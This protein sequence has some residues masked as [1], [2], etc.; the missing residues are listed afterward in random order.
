MTNKEQ[1]GCLCGAIRYEA[2]RSAVI[3]GYCCYCS[4]CQKSTGGGYAAYVML[5]QN[6]LKLIA[7]ELKTYRTTGSSGGH[8]QRSFCSD[9]GSP[10]TS[11]SN[12]APDFV[13][14]KAGSFDDSNWITLSSGYWKKSARPWAMPDGSIP[15]ADENT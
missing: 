11:T 6:E 15:I 8:I 2:D 4:D 9:C 14:V 12:I 10:I 5:P 3:S 1:G 13:F 7:G